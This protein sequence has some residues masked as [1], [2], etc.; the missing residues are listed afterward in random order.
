MV[1][2]AVIKLV[3]I[4]TVC[5]LDNKTLDI[6]AHPGESVLL[7]CY[8]TDHKAP[9]TFT[10]K[11]YNVNGNSWEEVSDESS[12]YKDRVQLFNSHSPGNLSLLISHLTEEDGG[13]YWCNVEGSGYRYIR[14]TVEGCIQNEV[15][16][17]ISAHPGGS[18]LLPCSCTDHN[19]PKTF[20]WKRYR[21]YGN[22][23]DEVSIESGQY[24][25]R[26]QLFN[27]HSPG[28]LSLLISHLTEEDGGWYSCDVGESGYRDIILTIKDSPQSLPFVPFALATV[29]LLHVVVAVVYCTMREKVPDSATAIYSNVGEDGA[30]RLQ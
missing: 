12:Q 28:N 8:C 26:V 29:I 16:L 17:N 25:D 11:N 27:S 9:K 5:I 23:W 14:L 24:R 21:V 3:C 4:S 13:L 6:R 10:W 22:S 15:T 2:H 18:V 1:I 7:P 30:V 20:T 19:T